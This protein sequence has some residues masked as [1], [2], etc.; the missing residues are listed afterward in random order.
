MDVILFGPPGA[1]KGT[2]ASTA[3]EAAGV[4]HV[5]TGDIFRHH[6]KNGTELG[7]K[8]RSYMN[9]GKLVPDE[10]VLEVVASRL[11]RDDAVGGVLFDGFPR[12][13]NQAQ[14]LRRWLLDHDRDINVVL[15]LVVPDHVVESRLSGRRSCR[16]CGATYHVEFSPP[17][18]D[19]S[20]SKCGADEVVQRA[21]DQPET[22]RKRIQT[23]HAQTAAVLAWAR[24][25]VRVVDIDADQ[26]IATVRAAVL[27]ALR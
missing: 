7:Q 22:V 15:N 19:G 9:E 25:H 21:D 11:E 27:D 1:G 17:A 13:V 6:L 14:L 12:T 23:Y 24:G 5:S 8:V 3:S 10:L 2:Q 26:A 18:Q 20:C 16:S 4:P